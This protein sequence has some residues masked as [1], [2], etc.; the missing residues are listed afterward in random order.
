MLVL[1]VIIKIVFICQSFYYYYT[2]KYGLKCFCGLLEIKP[3]NFSFLYMP[4]STDRSLG[5][6]N[7]LSKSCS[8]K[9]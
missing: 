5:Y 3:T 9:N 8:R 7:C 4:L 1:F 6:F 2:I